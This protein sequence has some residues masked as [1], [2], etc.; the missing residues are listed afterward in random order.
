VTLRNRVSVAAAVGVLVVV[1]AVSSVLYVSYAASL[2]SRVDAELVDTAQQA[3]SILDRTAQSAA[4]SQ[5]GANFEVTVGSVKVELFLKPP[6]AVGQPTRF[7]PLDSA[8]SRSPRTRSPR[9]LPTRTT[10]LSGFGS[11]PP[12]CKSGLSRSWCVPVGR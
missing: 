4:H 9:T 6:P 3:S 7:G 11:T 12:P 8:M 2:H 1:A 10:A 5:S